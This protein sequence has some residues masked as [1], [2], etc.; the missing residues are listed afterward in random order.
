[1]RV[2]IR[3]ENNSSCFTPSSCYPW[4]ILPSENHFPTW[5]FSFSKCR[6]RNLAQIIP[7]AVSPCGAC[8]HSKTEYPN[9]RQEPWRPRSVS[10]SLKLEFPK[11][12]LE[13]RRPT[14]TASSESGTRS[15]EGVRVSPLS[16]C[17]SYQRTF[18][19]LLIFFHRVACYFPTFQIET[20]HGFQSP[21]RPQCLAG[22]C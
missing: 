6:T 11:L 8:W 22:I 12:W 4:T 5:G 16:V 13:E 14:H 19:L 20:R 18:Q 3:S 1:M 15:G 21:S 2:R 17:R 7:E 10:P 9:L